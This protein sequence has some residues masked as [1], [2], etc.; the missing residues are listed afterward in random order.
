MVQAETAGG[1]VFDSAGETAGDVSITADA[2]ESG[3]S[4]LY[5]MMSG[6]GSIGNPDTGEST[7][8]DDLDAAQ[9][10]YV[11]EGATL[12]VHDATDLYSMGEAITHVYGEGDVVLRS[13]NGVSEDYVYETAVTGKTNAT[14]RLII[15]PAG[16]HEGYTCTRASRIHLGFETQYADISSFASIIVT[17]NEHTDFIV[18]SEL[19]AAEG[20]GHLNNVTVDDASL[21]VNLISGS[22]HLAGVTSLKSSES[23]DGSNRASLSFSGNNADIAMNIDELVDGNELPDTSIGNRDTHFFSIGGVEDTNNT[24]TVNIGSINTKAFILLDNTYSD[25]VANFN[26]EKGNKFWQKQ[27]TG[28]ASPGASG[29]VSLTLTGEGTYVLTEGAGI[30]DNFG[31]LSTEVDAETGLHKWR[32]TVEVTNL[33]ATQSWNSG[34]TK[35]GIDLSLYGNSDSYVHFSGVKGYFFSSLDSY[36]NMSSDVNLILTDTGSDVSSHAF[37]I[38]NGFSNQKIRFNGGIQG[39]GD[40]MINSSGRQLITFAGDLSDWANGGEIISASSASVTFIEDAIQINPDVKTEGGILNA[41]IRNTSA[42]AVGGTF[43]DA[44]GGELRLTVDTAKGTTFAKAFDVTSLT[45]NEDSTANVTAPSYAGNVQIN[46]RGDAPA[47]VSDG[48]VISGNSISNGKAENAILCFETDDSNSVS[49]ATLENVVLTSVAGSRVSLS[50]IEATGVYL[51]GADVDFHTLE[52]LCRFSVAEV[53]GA[54]DAMYNEVRFETSAF[55]GMTLADDGASITLGV[56]NELS[57]GDFN[58]NDAQSNVTIVLK[59][60]TLEGVGSFVTGWPSEY[61]VFETDSE[62]F[63]ETALSV[64]ALLDIDQQQ[65]QYITCQQMNDGLVI[66]MQHIIPEPATATLSLLAFAALASRRRRR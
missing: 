64:A 20:R 38:V 51:M 37:E 23:G 54:G 61:L 52:T 9:G 35:N 3:D 59:G 13:A 14:G 48:M 53:A 26:I 42:V 44:A 21:A 50:D 22:Y 1:A 18:E 25:I 45:V 39:N 6:W 40:M 56:S 27:Y 7:G 36:L 57:W 12:Y 30:R 28:A 65:Y 11:A 15:N 5:Y 46:R 24:F 41:T 62:G 55:A 33:N 34:T 17:G 16:E 4:S 32:G 10:W 29:T 2:G 8:Q 19:G 63:D 60:F 49:S 31:V 58:V 66:R 47:T 43:S